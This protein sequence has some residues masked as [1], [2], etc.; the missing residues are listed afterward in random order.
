MTRIIL[1]QL[2]NIFKF[3]LFTSQKYNIDESHGIR[4]SMDVLHYAH[5]IYESE[6]TINPF[7]TNHQ[8]IIYA[9]A[10]LHD[11]CDKKYVPENE[12]IKEIEIF[13]E[14]E[15][16]IKEIEITKQIISTM[17]YSTVKKVGYPNLEEYQ[18]AYH[19]VREADLLAAY[20]F[21]RCLIY[22]IYKLNGNFDSAYLDA[23]KLFENRVF[24]HLDDNLFVTEYSKTIAS[25]LHLN[26]I[27]RI[28]SWKKLT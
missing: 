26:S 25:Q 11:M 21:D 27:S 14:N 15:L 2:N 7:L 28:N 22:N 12:G 5:N 8:N 17:S 23:V 19:I 6:K 18:L 16:S 10:L 1:K 24:K 9:S 20:D 3:I 13:L 4:H